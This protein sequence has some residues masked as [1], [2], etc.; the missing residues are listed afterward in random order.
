MLTAPHPPQPTGGLH[1]TV[2][3]DIFIIL[4]S[5]QIGFH[6]VMYPATVGVLY[7]MVQV[8]HTW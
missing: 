5:H 2:Q 4:N 6:V 1:H 3:V 7:Y 8:D